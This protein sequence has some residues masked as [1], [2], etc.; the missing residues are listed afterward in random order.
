MARF[1]RTGGPV[2]LKAVAD[3]VL[4]K[5]A[6]G[7]VR[8]G[9]GS[10]DAVRQAAEEFVDRFGARLRGLLV[11]PMASAGAELLVGVT[12][13][14]VF[15]PLVAVGLGGT[16]TDLA[17]DRTHRLVPLSDADAEEMLGEF[18]AGEKL[19]DPGRVPA[20]DR[21]AVREVIVR[22][23]RLAELLPEVVELDLN[24]V[25]AGPDGCVAVDARIRVAPPPTDDP[26]LRALRI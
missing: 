21:P 8:L 26:A 23:A 6:A 12:S 22:V 25:L 18:R 2:A 9:L 3:G 10:A 20:V 14:A 24:P 17:L 4:H 1:S 19:F 5:A 7:G 13:D 15:G 11:Q 16:V